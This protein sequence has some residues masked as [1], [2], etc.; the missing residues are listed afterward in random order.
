MHRPLPGDPAEIARRLPCCIEGLRTA[1]QHPRA[2]RRLPAFSTA[3][4]RYIE[5]TDQTMAAFRAGHLDQARAIVI[6]PVQIKLH[7]EAIEA[8]TKNLEVNIQQADEKTGA[9]SAASTHATWI[10]V[11]MTL[12]IVAVSILIGMQLNRFV[13]PRIHKVVNLAERLAAK[14]MT[15]HV[16]VTAADELGRMG[17]ALN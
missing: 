3:F 4:S 10:S 13:T 11:I 5:A 6:D 17:D 15:A 14:D 2:T 7:A 8:G 12:L 9:V 1:H 16:V